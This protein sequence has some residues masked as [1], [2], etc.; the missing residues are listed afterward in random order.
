MTSSNTILISARF[1]SV[2]TLILLPYLNSVIT[3][4]NRCKNY[5]T[6]VALRI[7]ATTYPQHGKANTVALMWAETLKSRHLLGMQGDGILLNHAGYNSEVPTSG[8]QFCLGWD[9]DVLTGKSDSIL[10]G[11]NTLGSN[12]AF[13]DLTFDSTNVANIAAGTYYAFAEFNNL[14]SWIAPDQVTISI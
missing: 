13:I 3:A 12:G 1:S 8:G 11:L 9:L 10:S 6:E 2:K 7:G 4:N 14:V 5:L